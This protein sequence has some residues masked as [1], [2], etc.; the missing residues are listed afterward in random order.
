MKGDPEST[1]GIT[2]A[3]RQAN[4]GESL[5][6]SPTGLGGKVPVRCDDGGSMP[7]DASSLT[8]P[9]RAAMLRFER[10][11]EDWRVAS[12]KLLDAEQVVLAEFLRAGRVPPE[13]NVRI[14]RLRT[15]ERDARR[16]ALAAREEF[17]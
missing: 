7:R 9:Q 14:I 15:L 1:R 12:M 8:R 2:F 11:Y 4:G 3:H 10:L 6:P 17:G 5:E 13:M 16:E